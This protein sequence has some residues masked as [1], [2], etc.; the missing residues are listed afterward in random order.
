[1]VFLCGERR[2]QYRELDRCVREILQPILNLGHLGYQICGRRHKDSSAFERKRFDMIDP[3]H[4]K[5]GGGGGGG[6]LKQ[7]IGN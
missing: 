3:D 4:S 5:R 1:M 6:E 2:V 7:S